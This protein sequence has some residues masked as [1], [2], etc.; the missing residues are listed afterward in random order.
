MSQ[1]INCI[2]LQCPAPVLKTKEYL[3][4]NPATHIQVIVDNDAAVENVTRFLDFNKFKVSVESNATGHSIITGNRDSKDIHPMTSVTGTSQQS[5]KDYQKIMIMVA[6][7]TLGHGNSE[8][9]AKLM[10]NFINTLKEIGPDLWRL[11]FVNH[12]VRLA[13]KQS[14]VLE[15]L[16]ELETSGVSILVCG[17]CLTHL[18]LMKEKKVGETTNMLDI[19]TS[20]Q[21]ADKVINM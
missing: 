14:P 3:E 5:N 4:Q 11:V 19:I 21:L 6:S 15:A 2:D 12:G 17:A 10:V 16:L 20:M 1:T 18:E 8:L 13:T 7:D 9:G